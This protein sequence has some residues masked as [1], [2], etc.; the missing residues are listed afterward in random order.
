M[1]VGFDLD[2]V[3]FNPPLPFYGLIKKINLDFLM[4]R[5]RKIVTVKNAFYS[6]IR[7]NQSMVKFLNQLNERGYGIVIISGHSNECMEEVNACLRNSGVPFN[8]L[9]LF[10]EKYKSYFQF[11][12]EKI[13]EAACNFYVEDRLDIVQFLRQR[14]GDACQI[15]HYRN[16][17]S[18]FELKQI[19]EI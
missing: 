10:E 12:L 5:F 1:I 4:Y 7:V 19:L 18:L 17:K 16:K 2:G 6:F 14:L 11:K 8:G 3:I 9:C 13:I 15:V